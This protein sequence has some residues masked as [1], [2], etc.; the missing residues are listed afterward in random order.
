MARYSDTLVNQF[1]APLGGA[2]VLV[3]SANTGNLATLTADGGAALDNP[4][5]T[6]ADGT[7]YFNTA[8]G[9]YN[10][11]FLYGGRTIGEKLNVFVGYG[12]IADDVARLANGQVPFNLP[13]EADGQTIPP[14]GSRLP[15]L[16][17]GI[18]EIRK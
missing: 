15:Y 12:G 18:L 16:S 2:L 9:P 6:A 14:A 11:T 13:D 17:G 10:L 1:G 4:L 3:A 5:K 8:D 7:Y